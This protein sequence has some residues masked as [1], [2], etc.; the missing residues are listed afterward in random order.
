MTFSKETEQKNHK[1]YK[2]PHTKNPNSKSNLEKE[3][4]S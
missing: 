2:E 3:Q 1:I 4:Q